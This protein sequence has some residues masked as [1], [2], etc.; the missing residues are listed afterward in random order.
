MGGEK[1]CRRYHSNCES[2]SP[3]HGRGK[4]IPVQRQKQISGITPAWA[5]KRK[6]ET[7][8]K[9]KCGDHPR[10]GGEKTTRTIKNRAG[11]GSP[12][13]GRGKDD[14][15]SFFLR[16]AGITPAWAGKRG[17]QGQAY[18]G[19]EDHPRMGG[20]KSSNTGTRRAK[21][22][23]PPHGRGKAKD[24]Q[25]DVEGKGITP[26]WAGKRFAFLSVSGEDG[27]HPRMGGEKTKKIP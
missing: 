20:E 5:G 13:H 26:A 10:M 12:P 2:G 22:G 3:P 27:D 21:W 11:E 14:C 9:K 24:S 8:Q 25:T 7:I 15:I 18:H 16:R 19:R 1:R 4:G 17:R 6:R 23:S